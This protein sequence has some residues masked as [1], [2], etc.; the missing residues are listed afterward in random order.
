ME[1]VKFYYEVICFIHCNKTFIICPSWGTQFIFTLHSRLIN[2]I[3]L[4][5]N[6]Y[7]D[8]EGQGIQ[9]LTGII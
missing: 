5:I 6:R 1:A 4:L 9:N 2:I 3:R 7:G 8:M